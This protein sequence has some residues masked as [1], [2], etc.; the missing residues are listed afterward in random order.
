MSIPFTIAPFTRES[1]WTIPGHK[2]PNYPDGEVCYAQNEALQ[3]D[4]QLQTYDLLPSLKEVTPREG[5]SVIAENISLSVEEGFAGEARLLVQELEK[6]GY[7]VTNN[8]QTV[9]AL[10]HFPKNSQ[11]R[12]DEHYRLDVKDNYI[13][14]S[15]GTPHAIFNGT[16]DAAL[17]AETADDSRTARKRGHQRL[18]RPALPRHDA[19]HLAQLYP[20]GRPLQTD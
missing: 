4:Y 14:I 18:P 3:T 13:T 11:A 15:G 12:N 16:Q 7:H 20:Q 19:R 10:C 2:A 17:A 6:I 5:V 1:Q 8:G 9:I